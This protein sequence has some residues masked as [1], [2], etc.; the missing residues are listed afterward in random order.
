M[1]MV[2]NGVFLVVLATGFGLIGDLSPG[3]RATPLLFL[4]VSVLV[5]I[6]LFYVSRRVEVV[7]G[8]RRILEDDRDAI[9]PAPVLRAVVPRLRCVHLE[10]S[11]QFFSF[12]KTG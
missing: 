4:F 3:L 2:K 10:N 9:V 11:A 12:L 5:R 8:D 6:Q 1:N 7:V